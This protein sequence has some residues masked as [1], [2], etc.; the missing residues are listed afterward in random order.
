MKHFPA[1]EMK[2]H[3]H[4]CNK[5]TGTVFKIMPAGVANACSECG[6]FR[7]GRPYISQEQFNQLM[8]DAAKGGH[9]EQLD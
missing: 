4:Q 3:C 2:R 7:K 1:P 9:H 5:T 6:C 8:P